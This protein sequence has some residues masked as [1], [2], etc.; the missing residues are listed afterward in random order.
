MDDFELFQ[1]SNQVRATPEFARVQELNRFSNSARIVEI[2]YQEID[3]FL[4]VICETRASDELFLTE[5]RSA[6]G[7]AMTETIRLLQNLVASVSALI[8]HSWCLYRRMYQLSGQF[9]EYE[10]EL[11]A[12]VSTDEVVQFVQGIAKHCLYQATGGISTTMTVVDMQNETFEKKVTVVTA[13]L[14]DFSWNEAAMRLIEH[15]PQSIDLRQILK[16]F[17]KSIGAFC[18]WFSQRTRVLNAADYQAVSD[19]LSRARDSC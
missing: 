15:A 18:D 8:D 12:R 17:H 14:L 5:N 2:N 10:E 16:N 9:P 11:I 4:W 6:W 19:Y 13:D 3:R 1:L 7:E